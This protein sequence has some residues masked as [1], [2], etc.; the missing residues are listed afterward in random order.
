MFFDWTWTQRHDGSEWRRGRLRST[1]PTGWCSW[2]GAWISPPALGSRATAGV[3]SKVIP[4][5]G[6]T[7]P[8][9]GAWTRVGSHGRLGG[10]SSGP[11]PARTT[12]R[13]RNCLAS[14]VSLSYDTD[15][16]VL[17]AAASG[18]GSATVV[19]VFDCDYDAHACQPIGRVDGAVQESLFLDGAKP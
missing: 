15:G 7:R 18:E 1:W 12:L 11:H 9:S 19:R 16:S 14:C 17:A 6:S 5:S 4:A 8:A 3:S 10:L 2:T 13:C